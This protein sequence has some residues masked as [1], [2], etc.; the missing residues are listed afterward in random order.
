MALQPSTTATESNPPSS[1]E[2]MTIE[3]TPLTF[4]DILTEMAEDPACEIYLKAIRPAIRSQVQH[5]QK[6]K[7]GDT[8][9]LD[10]AARSELSKWAASLKLAKS[11]KIEPDG[12]FS[13]KHGAVLEYWKDYQ[14]QATQ[15]GVP[16]PV[17]HCGDMTGELKRRALKMVSKFG[18]CRIDTCAMPWSYMKAR[19]LAGKPL[20][21]DAPPPKRA[22]RQTAPQMNAPQAAPAVKAVRKR[23]RGR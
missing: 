2:A 6:S 1:A 15:E 5:E 12:T 17:K 16:P 23:S 14:M 11:R 8:R 20:E 19:E 9:E 22:T 3:A 4:C 18:K 7:G 10:L 21:W 13:R